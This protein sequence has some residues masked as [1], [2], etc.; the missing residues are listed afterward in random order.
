M[1]KSD[2][3]LKSKSLPLHFLYIIIYIHILRVGSQ[4]NEEQHQMIAERQ[5]TLSESL[6]EDRGFWQDIYSF[7]E[8]CTKEL[9]ELF[10]TGKSESCSGI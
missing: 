7:F 5:K 3:N 1:I 6:R 8:A 2:L 4:T 10:N 9:D